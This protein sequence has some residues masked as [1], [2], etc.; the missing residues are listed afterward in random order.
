M[1]VSFSV[2]D[3]SKKVINKKCIL[4]QNPRDFSNFARGFPVFLSHKELFK[5]YEEFVPNKVITVYC[6]V[7]Y[8]A[9]MSI[10]FGFNINF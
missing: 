5:K 7:K 10:D 6:E 2:V 3:S 8:S 4:N 1:D 9:T